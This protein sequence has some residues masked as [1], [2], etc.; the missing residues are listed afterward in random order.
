GEV[1][2]VHRNARERLQGQVRDHRVTRLRETR[3]RAMVRRCSRERSTARPIPFARST[4]AALGSL[5]PYALLIYLPAVLA[6]GCA[7][8]LPPTRKPSAAITTTIV[9]AANSSVA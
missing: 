7:S 3:R 8:R 2:K 9:T 5:H 6:S 4:Q 1:G